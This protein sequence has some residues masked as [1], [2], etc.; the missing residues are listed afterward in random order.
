[1]KEGGEGGELPG[2]NSAQEPCFPMATAGAAATASV[3]R[4]VIKLCVVQWGVPGTSGD[5]VAFGMALA[6]AES[7]EF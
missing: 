4:S 7:F 1:M 5:A 2:R 6:S 3:G